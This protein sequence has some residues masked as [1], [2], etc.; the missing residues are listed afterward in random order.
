MKTLLK[1]PV[2]CYLG[3]VLTGAS[4]GLGVAGCVST[5]PTVT[6]GTNGLPVTNQT[7]VVDTNRIN[8]AVAAALGI[9]AATAPLNPYAP[10]V[11]PVI[12]EIGTLVFL[13]STIFA[14]IKNNQK[15][16]MLA[17]VVQGVEGA[18]PP[19]STDSSP[20]T[21]AQVKQ[22]IQASA[23]AAGVQ[24]ALHSVVQANT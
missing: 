18:A 22:S 15:G 12:S 11:A 9:N 23:S 6:T 3:I 24:P 13:A 1:F 17:A 14:G 8:A 21:L 19:G 10:I 4:I 5:V 20:I 16:A 2:L 7:A